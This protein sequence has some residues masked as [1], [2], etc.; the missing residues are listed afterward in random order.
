L[1]PAPRDL[2]PGK[3]GVEAV[4]LSRPPEGTPI[5]VGRTRELSR[6]REAYA[7]SSTGT[8]VAVLVCGES[9]IGKSTLVRHFT[10][11]LALERPDVVRLEGRC[12]ERESIAYKA[13]DGVVDAIT[14]RLSRMTAAEVAA[15]LPRRTA[16]L[17][18]VFPVLLRVPQIAKGHAE[19]TEVVEPHELRE[20]AFDAL[21]SLV[22]RI[23]SKR[24]TVIVIDDLQWADHDGLAALSEILRPPDAPAVLL[25]ATVRVA[26]QGTRDAGLLRV[27]AAMPVGTRIVDLP[28]LPR[29]D[30]VALAAQILRR[31]AVSGAD[32]HVIATEAAGHPLFVEELA[33]HLAG[34]VTA[35]TTRKL[36]DAIGSRIE[37]LEERTRAVV[38]LVAIAGR[39]IPQA[40]AAAAV[41]VDPAAFHRATQTLK[42]A[43]LVRTDGARWADPIEPYHDRVREAVAAR[44]EPQRKRGLHEA[45]AIAFERSEHHDPE[46]LATHWREA[47]RTR[48]AARHAEKAGEEA[49]RALAFDRAAQWYEQALSMTPE[50]EGKERRRTLRVL[51]GDALAAAGRGALAAPHYEAAAVESTRL[52]AIDLRRRAAE[53][54]LRC[55]RFEEGM[56]ASRTV[57][58]SAGMRLPRTKL[59]T[60]FVLLWW[61][62]VLRVRG[63]D[64][65][66]RAALPIREEERLRIDV[67]WSVGEAVTPTD[68]LLGVAFATR[69]LLLALRYG[70]P[71]RVVR[72]FG[73][74]VLG[75]ATAGGASWPRTRSELAKLEALGAKSG[76]ARSGV[77]AAGCAGIALY[78]SGRFADGAAELRKMIDLVA[79]GAPDMVFERV[80]TR[81]ILTYA[82]DFLGRYADLQ[83]VAGELL[84]DAQA[85]GDL[86]A[87][88]LART[89]A[90][91][92]TWLA[93]DRPD[94][95]EEQAL[96]A[97]RDWS[98]GGF[99]LPHWYGLFAR[100]RARLYV[101]DASEA[102]TLAS[103]LIEHGSASLLWRIQI[104]RCTAIYLRAVSAVLLAQRGL[105]DRAH[106]LRTA[107]GD[108]RDLEAEQAGWTEGLA[109]VIRAGVASSEGKTDEAARTL[110]EAVKAFEAAG[111]TGYAWAARDRAARRRGGE[112]AAEETERAEA[113]FRRENVVN[114]AR[115]MGML[116]P[117]LYDEE[118]GTAPGSLRKPG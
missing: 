76:T 99:H 48:E 24:P 49:S 10:R 106:L 91:A 114:P 98:S 67:C 57:V 110:D 20:Q 59:G 105:G 35:Q 18:L 3:A 19:L 9:G 64:F 86:Y 81:H 56:A 11:Q 73:F 1:L 39:P 23:A 13:L 68:L 90:P 58:A 53:Q 97:L 75:S 95:A 16:A 85:R 111:M 2:G 80:T 61:T 52:E 93:G 70:D 102:Q 31:S 63:M 77:Y 38:E 14:R 74:A 43:S 100:V 27:Q 89:G 62:L 72:A 84:R 101:G 41:G 69:S 50:E 78:L 88:V 87:S 21:R 30:A 116:V 79:A 109:R 46:M 51:L 34:G 17:A 113:F 47:G 60:L 104:N 25:V 36:D 37:E 8:L 26:A 4:A 7:A 115:M 112:G 65:E 54:L 45:L 92:L 28:R 33:R 44:V 32:P 22:A 107:V 42:T 15:V 29:E 5:F 6:L 118:I 40:V 94:I 108:A 117:G 55:G 96:Q 66:E 103:E 83:V 12:Y 71:E 82:C